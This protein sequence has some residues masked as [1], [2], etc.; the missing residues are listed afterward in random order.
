M[1]KIIFL[2]LIV[3][4]FLLSSQNS[5]FENK[6][7]KIEKTELNTINSDFGPAFVNNEL[8]YSAF[9]DQEIL[10]L[11]KGESKNIYCNLYSSELDSDGNIIGVKTNHLDSI[12]ENYHAGPVSYCE[13]TEELFVTLSNFEDPDIRNTIYVKS[14]IRLKIIILKKIDNVWTITGSLPF[15]SAYYSVGH[16]SIS[17]TGDTLYF[18]SNIPGFGGFGE[19]DIYMSIRKDGEWGNPINL[20]DEIN[21]IDD[22]MFPYL[23]K[24][25]ILIFSSNSK[26]NNDLDMLY[27]H[28]KDGVFTDPQLVYELNTEY[29]DFGLTM[30]KSDCVGYFNTNTK[31]D[32]ND[33]IYKVTFIKPEVKKP[34]PPIIV[35]IPKSIKYVYKNIFYDFLIFV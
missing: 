18:S 3:L 5:L 7:F 16:P 6:I 34:E 33:D 14:D 26:P 20:G 17:E 21:T 32:T 19:T 29:D 8:W 4:P 23:Y 31:E 28:L 15:N 11:S 9:T 35:S 1:K 27:S 2:I 22:E 30:H 12:S 24:N 25:N 10:D 13:K